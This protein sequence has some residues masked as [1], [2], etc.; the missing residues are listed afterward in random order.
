[1]SRCVSNMFCNQIFKEVQI[2]EDGQG[3]TARKYFADNE[4]AHDMTNCSSDHICKS[5]FSD[6]RARTKSTTQV[7]KFL[8]LQP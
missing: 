1:M 7:P 2:A 3:D 6:L 5:V 4:V 8:S